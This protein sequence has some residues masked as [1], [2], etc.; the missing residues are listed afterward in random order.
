M[1]ESASK[2]RRTQSSLSFSTRL[3]FSYSHSGL[4]RLPEY[5]ECNQFSPSGKN[6]PSIYC[7]QSRF[8]RLCFCNVAQRVSSESD[9]PSSIQANRGPL[10][11]SWGQVLCCSL[12]KVRHLRALHTLRT[13]CTP[14]RGGFFV[15]C[16]K[17]IWES[18]QIKSGQSRNNWLLC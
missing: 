10:G 4:E 7:I 6:V 15:S 9:L 18:S 14:D 12:G 2:I 5:V 8:Y 17:G 3:Y 1:P 16:T 11:A 13:V